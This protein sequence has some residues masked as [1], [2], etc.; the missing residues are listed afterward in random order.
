MTKRRKKFD[1]QKPSHET[2]PA[3]KESTKNFHVVFVNVT[4]HQISK[5]RAKKAWRIR[6][7]L[8]PDRHDLEHVK[9]ENQAIRFHRWQKSSHTRAIRYREVP[10][11]IPFATWFRSEFLSSGHP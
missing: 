4:H 7:F 5:N 10:F 9:P 11:A 6:L 1:P 2:A 3:G 8:T